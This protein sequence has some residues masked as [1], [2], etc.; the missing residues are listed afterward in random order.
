MLAANP[1]LATRST[2]FANL[3]GGCRI[4]ELAEARTEDR[5]VENP[6]SGNP[7]VSYDVKTGGFAS[8]P[9]GGFA[10]ISTMDCG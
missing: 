3:L 4:A 1:M 10:F 9:S 8:P 5:N 6:T 7:A 2:P